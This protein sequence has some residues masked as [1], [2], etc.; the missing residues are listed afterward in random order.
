[1]SVDFPEA[2]AL[3]TTT[4]SGFSS[5]REVAADGK[6][7]TAP[8]VLPAVF[9]VHAKVPKPGFKLSTCGAGLWRDQV[10]QGAVGVADL[11][12]FDCLGMQAAAAFKVLARRRVV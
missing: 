5:L 4:A 8:Q 6:D 9:A 10:C 1:M 7:H 2:L 12:V 3:C 11:K